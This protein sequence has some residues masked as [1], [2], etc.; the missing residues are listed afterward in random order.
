[1]WK[2]RWKLVA[3]DKSTVLAESSFDAIVMQD[4]Q[5]DRRL[6][7]PSSTNQSDGFQA[8][9]ETDYLIDYFFA[10]ET[11]PRRWGR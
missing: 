11:G 3:A 8:L 9:N 4:L 1:M 7:N 5:G 10:S 6:T 2:G